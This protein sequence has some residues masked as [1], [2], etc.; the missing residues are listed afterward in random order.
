MTR[1]SL[2]RPQGSAHPLIAQAARKLSRLAAALTHSKTPAAPHPVE[3]EIGKIT[4]S[5]P[6]VRRVI[7]WR[8]SG[9]RPQDPL[10][11]LGH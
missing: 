5:R 4:A 10:A 7:T 8:L 2:P 3:A 9:Q 1:T 6:G 11:D